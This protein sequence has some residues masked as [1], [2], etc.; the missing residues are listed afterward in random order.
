M[1]P[2]TCSFW[3]DPQATNA[4]ADT[5]SL[6]QQYRANQLNFTWLR[7]R[8]NPFPRASVCNSDR[9]GSFQEDLTVDSPTEG[10]SKPAAVP[11][12][13]S[14][15]LSGETS[16]DFSSAQ[17]AGRL[18]H[19]IADSMRFQFRVRSRQLGSWIQDS[20]NASKKFSLAVAN[21]RHCRAR[22]LCSH[23]K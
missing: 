9:P 20:Q 6:Y 2:S 17:L 21:P 18:T 7:Q 11:K 10:P 4:N 23:S 8:T 5:M 22:Q 3:Q 16:S 14:C 12:S 15:S 13:E 19:P 1:A